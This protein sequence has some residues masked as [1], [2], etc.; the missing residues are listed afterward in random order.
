MSKYVYK[1]PLRHFSL[2]W[3][4]ANDQW[5]RIFGGKN[6]DYIQFP[7]F[8]NT[9]KNSFEINP[10][11]FIS[12]IKKAYK[13]TP[14]IPDDFQQKKPLEQSVIFFSFFQKIFIFDE[15]DNFVKNPNIGPDNFKKCFSLTQYVIFLSIAKIYTELTSLI[16]E[17]VRGQYGLALIRAFSKLMIPN[18]SRIFQNKS[19]D[20]STIFISPAYYSS[21]QKMK[22]PVFVAFTNENEME[23]LEAVNNSLIL[24]V[25]RNVY[26]MVQDKDTIEF[27]NDSINPDLVIQL[28][29]ENEASSIMDLFLQ[30]PPKGFNRMTTFLR[31]IAAFKQ[32]GNF[33]IEE[34][35]NFP[36]QLINTI[37]EI[38]SMNGCEVLL[39]AC[40]LPKNESNMNKNNA[41]FIIKILGNKFLPFMRALIELNFNDLDDGTHLFLQDNQL[42][43]IITSLINYVSSEYMRYVI[44]KLTSILAENIEQMNTPV[45]NLSQAKSFCENI[46]LPCLDIIISSAPIMNDTLKYILRSFF[47]RASCHYPDDKACLYVI[48]NVLL[49]KIILP[50]FQ[51]Q[52]QRFME[53]THLLSD[54]LKLFFSLRSWDEYREADKR[55]KYL[56]QLN[57][58]MTDNFDRV[59]EFTNEILNCQKCDY[60]IRQGDYTENVLIVD[61]IENASKRAS[62]MNL[63]TANKVINSHMDY[64]SV[65]QMLEEFIFDFSKQD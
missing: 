43:F 5:H 1:R 61:F 41:L 32:M 3:K 35:N 53:Y 14:A 19:M 39:Y 28:P 36:I 57:H 4:S 44:P 30:P 17:N 38:I 27:Y 33:F 46:F 11:L 50:V 34:Y 21:N 23:I 29:S 63:P 45:S 6:A 42:S 9:L 52:N 26:S 18:N 58:F 62:L 37:Q 20:L 64:V 10:D 54:S 40:M 12:S 22:T 2:D 56:A 60:T 55:G 24:K 65:M 7:Q 25:K 31:S 59:K 51:Q 48:S 47:I 13:L 16:R 49:S 15:L 8:L